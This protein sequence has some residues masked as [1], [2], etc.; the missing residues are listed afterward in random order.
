MDFLN[1]LIVLVLKM[2]ITFV[3][4]YVGVAAKNIYAK[5]VNDDTK[6]KVASMCVNAVEQ[7][8]KDL[9]GDEKLDECVKRVSSILCE[10]GIYVDDYEMRT[11]IES[12][13]KEMNDGFTNGC[14][15]K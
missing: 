9:H 12:A 5:Y 4:G 2:L 13:V 8:Y 14:V 6:R 10:K 15:T 1:E 11:L 7:M 3:A